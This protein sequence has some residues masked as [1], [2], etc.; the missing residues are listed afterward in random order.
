MLQL[1]CLCMRGNEYVDNFIYFFYYK[2]QRIRRR[3]GLQFCSLLLLLQNIVMD[4]W[5]RLTF[6]IHRIQENIML[7]TRHIYI[8]QVRLYNSYIKMHRKAFCI[9]LTQF[10]TIFF[11]DSFCVV[12]THQQY[13][14]VVVCKIQYKYEEQVCVQRGEKDMQDYNGMQ[15]FYAFFLAYF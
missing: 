15:P 7:Y 14:D 6:K 12:T 3:H 4:V 2:M 8:I 13:D 9:Y 11:F 10:C 1:N 5:K